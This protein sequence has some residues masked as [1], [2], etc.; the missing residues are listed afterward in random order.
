M[1]NAS[2]HPEDIMTGK[3]GTPDAIWAA[4]NTVADQYAEFRNDTTVRVIYAGAV[5]G[6]AEINIYTIPVPVIRNFLIKIV[7][8]NTKLIFDDAHEGVLFFSLIK[9]I[10]SI[11]Q[12]SGINPK[13]VYYCSATLNIDELYKTFCSDNN[14]INPINVYSCNIWEFATWQRSSIK[15]RHNVIKNKEK[16]FLC[17]NRMFRVHRY[18]LLG[19]LLEKD[20]VK[21][22]YYSFFFNT[23]INSIT[24]DGVIPFESAFYSLNNIVSSEMQDRVNNQIKLHKNIF[25]LKVNIENSENNKNYLDSDD[26]KF[27]DKSYFS[28]VT[29]TGF[30]EFSPKQHGN[31]VFFSEKIFKPILVRHPFIL[32]SAPHSL[33]YLRRLGYRTF[34]PFI[35]EE[36]DNIDNNENR[37]LAIVNEVER[38]SRFTP[39]QWIEWQHNVE[40]ILTHNYIVISSRKK[41]EYEF[42]KIKA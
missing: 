35:N 11:I 1:H 15:D 38:L 32:A 3:F 26:M 10:H 2:I 5:A 17:F 21:D 39:S 4:K 25:P 6:P 12:N 13:Q 19:L 33:K 28:L 41:N 31:T 40:E 7:K 34:S 22:A 14:I 27:F 8:P 18:A 24:G 23:Y 9:I 36:Y 37:L 42:S 16:L 20:L 29:E 30:F